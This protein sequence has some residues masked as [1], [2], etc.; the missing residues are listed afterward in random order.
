MWPIQ[1]GPYQ[2]KYLGVQ[3]LKLILIYSHSKLHYM[4]IKRQKYIQ[5]LAGM[6]LS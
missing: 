2:S 5:T 4:S 3:F 1:P 6:Y